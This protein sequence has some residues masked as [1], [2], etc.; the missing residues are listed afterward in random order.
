MDLLNCKLTTEYTGKKYTVT[1]DTDNQILACYRADT[2]ELMMQ[3]QYDGV[4]VD[5][6]RPLRD[7][8]W[9]ELRVFLPDKR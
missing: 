6:D 1:F 3:A 2:C 9:K 8:G 4:L 5:D 7:N